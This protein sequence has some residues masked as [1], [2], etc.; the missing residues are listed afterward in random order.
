MYFRNDFSTYY[1][2]VSPAY[3]GEACDYVFL[4]I[5]LMRTVYYIYG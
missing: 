1:G 2:S 3:Y 5:P 4:K